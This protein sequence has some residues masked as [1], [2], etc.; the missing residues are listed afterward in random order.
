MIGWM[1]STFGEFLQ[2]R[3]KIFSNRLSLRPSHLIQEEIEVEGY[4]GGFFRGT[5]DDESRGDG[6]GGIGVGI[7]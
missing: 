2:E 1:I 3:A 4:R 7:F 6:R 5:F